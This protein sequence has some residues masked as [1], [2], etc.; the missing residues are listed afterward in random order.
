MVATSTDV[1]NEAIQLIG[2]NQAP[3]TGI[4]PSFDTSAAGVAAAAIYDSVV[5]AVAREFNWDWTRQTLALVPSGNTPPPGLS[6]EYLYPAAAVQLW[7][8]LPSAPVDPNNPLPITWTV[9]NTLVAGVQTKVIRTN[10]VS[11]QAV[12]AIALTNSEPLW[13]SLFRQT[14]VHMLAS[15]LAMALVARPDTARDMLDSAGRFGAL[16]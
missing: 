9:A 11:A 5:A 13:D 15:E 7:Q 8:L 3:V 16:V 4:A 1:V 14:V 2:N 10:L 6:Q 12:C